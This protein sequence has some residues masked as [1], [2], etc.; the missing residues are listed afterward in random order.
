LADDRRYRYRG[1]LN[2]ARYGAPLRATSAANSPNRD[3]REVQQAWAGSY[4]EVNGRLKD[5]A[6]PSVD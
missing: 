3:W 6:G 1:L 5:A 4:Y 2:A